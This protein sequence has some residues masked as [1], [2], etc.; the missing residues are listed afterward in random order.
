MSF[1]ERIWVYGP[2]TALPLDLLEARELR[3]AGDIVAVGGDSG[4]KWDLTDRG[5]MKFMV[6]NH[7]TKP[8]EVIHNTLS[9]RGNNYGSFEGHANI[10]QT[11]KRAMTSAP[12]WGDLTDSQR[13]SLDMVVHKIGRILNGNPNYIDSWRDI[14]GYSQLVV[15]ELVTHEGARDSR[16]VKQIVKNGV[17]QDAE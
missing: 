15:D 10:T 2:Q 9:E 3:D 7:K 13:E 17:L 6:D 1:A 12:K 11:L 14:V 4:F 16:V 8:E 5:R